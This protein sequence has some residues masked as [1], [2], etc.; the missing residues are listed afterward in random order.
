MPFPPITFQTAEPQT[1]D[2]IRLW[3]GGIVDA[4]SDQRIHVQHAIRKGGIVGKRFVG[5][6]ET[7]LDEYYDT[8]RRELDRRT[9]LNLVASAEAEIRDNYARHV[10]GKGKHPLSQAYQAWHKTLP[11]KKQVR[12]DFDE[13]GILSVLKKAMLIDNHI[14]GQFRACM[15][16]RHWVGH[17][18]YWDKPLE[19]DRLDPDDVY[20]RAD[21]LLRALP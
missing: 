19:I 10:R 1:L 9:V 16:S 5:M 11:P 18:R 8:Q 6:T 2:E 7:E 21:A 17:G 13:R 14:V 3:H 20:A 15:K 4:L 12:P